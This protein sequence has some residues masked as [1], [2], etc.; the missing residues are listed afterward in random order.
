M[1][2]FISQWGHAVAAT[3]FGA[4]AILMIRRFDW[5]RQSRVMALACVTTAFWALAVSMS[6]ATSL[7]A[8][9]GD[10]LRNMAWLGLMYALWRQGNGTTRMSTVGVLYAV[11]A[12]V[13]VGS[14]VVDILPAFK[15]P[16]AFI[17]EAIF[18]SSVTLRMIFAVTALVLLH[19][20]YTA[21]TVDARNAIRFPM[22]GLS[23]MWV[24]DL[25]LYTISYLMQDWSIELISLRGVVISMLA[26]PFAL[27][28]VQTQRISMRLSRTA[29]FQSL[30]LVAIGSYLLVMILATSAIGLIAGHYAR[31]AQ[32]S[33]VFGSSV[34]GLALL[35]SARFRAW[36]RVKLAKHLFQH[37]YDYRAEWVRFTNTIGRADAAAAPL[38][39]RAVQ[40]IADIAEAEGGLLFTPD[41]QGALILQSR[42]NCATVEAPSQPVSKEL[43][44]YLLTTTRVVELDALRGDRAHTEDE[45]RLI[46]EWLISDQR[47]W[48][49]VPLIHI[50]RLAGVIVL[51]RP[52]VDRTLDWEDFD[53]LKVVGRQVASYLSEARGQETLSDVRQFDEFNRRF[54]FIMHDIKNLVSQLT[55]VTR[56]AERHADNPEF[57]SDMIATLKNSAARMNDLLARLSQHNKARAEDPRPIELGV[58]VESVAKPKRLA[59]P[60]VSGGTLQLHVVA[61]PTRLEQALSHLVQNAIEASPSSEPV[62]I[63]ARQVG[64]EVSIEILDHGHGMS[65][66]FIHQDLFKA[67]ASTKEGGFGIGAFEARSLINAMG[68]RLEVQS[69]EGEW[70]KFTLYLPIATQPVVDTFIP[71]FI[72]EQAKVA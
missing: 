71:E 48:A 52:K 29:T 6:G 10:N 21:A 16:A 41:D 50:N 65:S 67:F 34:I 68:G 51:E 43:G 23:V 60:I 57:R 22:I 11:L 17:V 37:R 36:I 24:Y 53:L 38:A 1:I 58:I 28:T 70:T 59:H 56:N 54:A 15:D 46:P 72:P 14:L 2:A 31:I 3:L 20:L 44:Q 63:T 35:P 47:L 18:F 5:D 69:R 64:R 26:A 8:L 25:N 30:S 33:F 40:A 42:W 39:S 45:A 7:P 49:L 66:Q 4:L 32:V 13:A 55:L 61:D 27:A 9:I 12:A 62:C 19:N